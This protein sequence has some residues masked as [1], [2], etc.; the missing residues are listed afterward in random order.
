MKITTRA[1]ASIRRNIAGNQLRA[2]CNAALAVRIIEQQNDTAIF[3]EWFDEAMRSAIV[4]IVM[5]GAALE[6]SANESIQNILDNQSGLEVTVGRKHLLEDLKYDRSGNSV[7][8]YRQMTWIFNKEPDL[9]S[10]S[11]QNAATL[12]LARNSLMHFRPVWDHFDD[13]REESKLV[14]A[15]KGNVPIVPAY[16]S[17]LCFPHAFMSYGCA[18]WAIETVSA[19]CSD[20]AELLEVDAKVVVPGPAISLP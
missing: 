20:V 6:A 1:V 8:K 2:A 18:K 4:A 10:P 13:A 11:W 14:K 9:G 3:G 15:L 19:L 5:A 17:Q 16:K 12:V 7:G